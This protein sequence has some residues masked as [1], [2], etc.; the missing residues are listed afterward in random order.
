MNQ[1]WKRHFGA[2]AMFIEIKYSGFLLF[3]AGLFILSS[4]SKNTLAPRGKVPNQLDLQTTANG[5]WISINSIHGQMN[6]EG[7]FMGFE[8]DSLFIM[9][10]RNLESI[11][12]N[13]VLSARLIFFNHHANQILAWGAINTA[14]SLLNGYFFI[15]TAPFNIG[16]TLANYSAESK[17]INYID[18]PQYNWEHFKYYAR[19]PQGLKGI[20]R[21]LL[22]ASEQK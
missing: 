13:D 16:I 9:R 10:E 6:I 14:A 18:Y 19:F 5:G 11:H 17:L 20:D 15:F 8:S 22:I 3:L 2:V 4:C 12:K 7:E 1:L 21:R